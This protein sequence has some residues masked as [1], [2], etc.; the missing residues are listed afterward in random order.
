VEVSAE[1]VGDDI[2]IRVVDA[3]VGIDVDP[4][5]LFSLFYRAPTAASHAA[6]SGV[7]LFVCA[8]LVEAMGGRIW[9]S[10][11]AEGGAEFG[12]A[13]RRFEPAAASLSNTTATSVT[14]A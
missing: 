3:G 7:G 12:I 14:P 5:M 4:A 2:L 10:P 8:R 6:G 11:R 13:L 1:A 9:A